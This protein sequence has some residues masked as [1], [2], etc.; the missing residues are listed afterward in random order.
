[1]CIS[2][3]KFKLSRVTCLAVCCHCGC[4]YQFM[5]EERVL[6]SFSCDQGQHLGEGHPKLQ[7]C[8]R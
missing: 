4:D 3:G 2:S 8:K 7:A 5:A 1:M 6:S